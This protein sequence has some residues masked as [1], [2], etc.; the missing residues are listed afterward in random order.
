[1]L[2]EIEEPQ[3]LL[4]RAVGGAA[5]VA[6]EQPMGPGAL[7][8]VVGDQADAELDDGQSDRV[9]DQHSPVAGLDVAGEQH[10]AVQLLHRLDW[11]L[12]IPGKRW[13]PWSAAISDDREH[14]GAERLLHPVLLGEGAG[15][16]GVQPLVERRQVRARRPG[17]EVE[18]PPE[19]LAELVLELGRRL[20]LALVASLA[21][22]WRLDGH[23]L[24]PGWV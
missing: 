24:A 11:K 19:R 17:G 23:L 5:Q 20:R 4:D 3:R 16:L 15:D 14:L 22:R 13:C 21:A 1:V 18:D 8:T 10:R 2:A 12:V 6:A 7:V 9:V